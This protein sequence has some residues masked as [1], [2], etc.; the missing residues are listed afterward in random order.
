MK[1]LNTIDN[2]FEDDIGYISSYDFSQGNLNNENRIKAITTVA[3]V[4]YDNPNII[5]K[6]SL[7]NRLARESAGLPSSSFEFVPVLL[8]IGQ[9]FIINKALSNLNSDKSYIL[10]V[11]KY[12][13]YIEE[14]DTTYLLTN[15]R[16]LLADSSYIGFN[17]E[18]YFN[19]L[20]ESLIIKKYSKTFLTKM[21]LASARQHNRHRAHLQEISRRYV[22]GLKTKL[23]FYNDP[24]LSGKSTFVNRNDLD[25]K[26]TD[27][28]VIESDVAEL[29]VTDLEVTDILLQEMAIEHYFGLLDQGVKPQH[30]R[31]VLPQSMYTTIWTNFLPFQLK[32]YLAIRDDDHAQT[33]IQIVAKSMKLLLELDDE[34]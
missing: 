7:Y 13:E 11:E 4:C 20:D 2:I 23:E 18:D 29:E 21:D 28:E 22:S 33:E 30:A 17:T 34:N 9:I 3:S 19:N 10:K 6:E 26:V 27:L 12:G 16:A 1:K 15:F 31:R 5:G 32:N 24:K 14:S 25:L 8:T